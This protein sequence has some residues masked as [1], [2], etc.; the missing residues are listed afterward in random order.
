VCQACSDAS[1]SVFNNNN[2]NKTFVDGRSAVAAEA[3]AEQVT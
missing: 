1:M 3:L 2:D